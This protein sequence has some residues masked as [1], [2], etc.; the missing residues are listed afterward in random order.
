MIDLNA[1]TNIVVPLR[2]TNHILDPELLYTIIM[3]T[4]IA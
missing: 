4:I 3:L 2:M 1:S